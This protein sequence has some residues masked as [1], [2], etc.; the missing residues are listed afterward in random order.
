[1][2]P[3]TK[4]GGIRGSRTSC[5]CAN[6]FSR[7]WKRNNFSVF[8]KL[9]KWVGNVCFRSTKIQYR[10]IIF[11]KQSSQDTILLDRIQDTLSLKDAQV[12]TYVS[13]NVQ[14]QKEVFSVLVCSCFSI[15]NYYSKWVKRNVLKQNMKFL[16]SESYS[17]NFSK[18]CLSFHNWSLPIAE[19]LYTSL[20]FFTWPNVKFSHMHP[21][22]IM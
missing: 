2:H 14:G 1:M 16:L 20:A 5:G 15:G 3:L 11:A 4:L 7:N 9:S 22:E 10:Y 13:E 17:F 8:L 18:L 21:R 19:H 12:Q 6:F